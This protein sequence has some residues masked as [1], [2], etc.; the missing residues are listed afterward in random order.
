MFVFDGSGYPSVYYVTHEYDLD[1]NR[2]ETRR[3]DGVSGGRITYSATY[4]HGKAVEETDATGRTV[5]T[6]YDI[7]DRK[8]LQVVEGSTAAGVGDITRLYGYSTSATGCGCT[9][10]ET[11][12]LNAAGTLE[13]TEIDETDRVCQRRFKSGLKLAV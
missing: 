10:A 2:T 1:R 11:T 12:I 8:E 6:V 3:F 13:L 4:E 7:L 5:E 9:A